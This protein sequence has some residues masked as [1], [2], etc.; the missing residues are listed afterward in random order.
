MLKQVE[1]LYIKNQN[2]RLYMVLKKVTGVLFYIGFFLNFLSK[3]I[4][5]GTIFLL[6]EITTNL[7]EIKK[8]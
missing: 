1:A 7:S 4:T 2:K 8:I 3:S 6:D 5:I